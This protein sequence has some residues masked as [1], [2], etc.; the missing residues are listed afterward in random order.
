MVN[1]M[2]S[3]FN[4][5]PKCASALLALACAVPTASAYNRYIDN[6]GDVDWSS[7]SLVDINLARN[8]FP[9]PGN[10]NGAMFDTVNIVNRN[11][12]HF[13]FDMNNDNGG[14]AQDNGQNEIW[15]DTGVGA[16]GRAHLRWRGTDMVEV[17][18]R[19]DQ[20]RAWTSSNNRAS[21]GAYDGMTSKIQS[22]II[23][24]L[25]H[26]FP[27]AHETDTYNVMG[28]AW[29]F[30]HADGNFIRV[31]VGEDAIQGMRRLYG[32]DE[33]FSDLS[34]THWK[35]T[36]DDG[37]Y[38]EHGRT[39]IQ[40]AGGAE[41]TN[42]N[43]NDSPRY[44]VNRGDTV[45]VEFTYENL[46][47]QTENFKV[48]LYASTSDTITSDD[49]LLNEVN[50][51]LSPDTAYTRK[52]SVDIPDRLLP[53]TDYSIGVI[54]DNR[55]SVTEDPVLPGET[56]NTSYIHIRTNAGAN[57]DAFTRW[58]GDYRGVLDGEP[59]RLKIDQRSF[60]Q[61]IGDRYD[62]ELEFLDS[63][64]IYDNGVSYD[65][66]SEPQVL[67]PETL[68]AADRTSIEIPRLLIHGFDQDF[69]SGVEEDGELRGVG[70]VREG[71]KDGFLFTTDP[72]FRFSR[73]KKDWTGT[74]NG[75]NDGRNAR[76]II[77]PAGVGVKR[78]KV[79]Q[80]FDVTLKD[81]D[82]NTTFRGTGFVQA[83]GNQS[84]RHQMKFFSPLAEAGGSGDKIVSRL[85][86]HT[87][88]RNFISGNTIFNDSPFGMFF[89]R[90]LLIYKAKPYFVIGDVDFTQDDENNT[91]TLENL[92]GDDDEGVKFDPAEQVSQF[93]VDLEDVDVGDG[94]EASV[95][96]VG[97]GDG[98]EVS[99]RLGSATLSRQNGQ[100]M[101][102][103]DFSAIEASGLRFEV[104]IFGDFQGVI[105][106]TDIVHLLEGNEGAP[107]LNG[108]GGF[109]SSASRFGPGA[110]FTFASP[111]SVAAG[112]AD[113]QGGAAVQQAS[114]LMG[115]EIRV[116]ATGAKSPS[117]GLDEVN[118]LASNFD[119]LTITDETSQFLSLEN[120]NTFNPESL[121]VGQQ[122]ETGNWVVF[123]QSSPLLDKATPLL[124][125]GPDRQGA[126]RALEVIQHY[127]M[128]KQIRF[129]ESPLEFFLASGQP[130]R[131]PIVGE[132][133]V[134]FDPAALSVQQV[135]ESWQVT[136][137]GDPIHPELSFGTN[138]QAAENA[139]AEILRYGFTKLC[140]VGNPGPQMTYFTAPEALPAPDLVVT[141]LDLAGDSIARIGEQ[142][143]E[144]I[145]VTV[146]N[147]S[148]S[149]TAPPALL[150]I[151]LSP[152]EPAGA[153]S[154]SD[155]Q[156]IGERMTPSLGPDESVDLAFDN[157]AKIP[158]SQ[159]QQGAYLVAFADFGEA[160][161]EQRENNN[162]AIFPL[163]IMGA[164]GELGEWVDE[165]GI[166]AAD[167]SKDLDNDGTRTLFEYFAGNDPVTPDAPVIEPVVIEEDGERFLALDV[168]T[169]SAG[170][171]PGVSA[172][173][174][175]SSDLEAFT[176]M[177][178][179][180]PIL[181]DGPGEKNWLRFRQPH[182]M[183][184]PGFDPFV[185][186]VVSET[187]E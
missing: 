3:R 85:L 180:A 176:G 146:E 186:L 61:H 172:E 15:F 143:G 114:P 132:D 127:E 117:R 87:G 125:F 113:A 165:K 149:E 42:L 9:G 67:E 163:G 65:I 40:D 154:P 73:F 118:L 36:G 121:A 155:F 71:P 76:L 129:A 13:S 94:S 182:P 68:V 171:P 148:K 187:Q 168:L 79:F 45:Q 141:G 80:K 151:L 90:K 147:Q 37:E 137:L 134:G 167:L 101:L 130:P 185:Q 2:I 179:G 109:D 98:D 12:S 157:L 77:K 138:R 10:F 93:E 56:N 102:T 58:L 97:D 184:E 105:D 140:F 62:I 81:Q 59:V 55:D 144:R 160:I 145:H 34:V 164:L 54:V 104:Y 136:E 47:T 25:G 112:G 108:A 161:P 100:L 107:R 72:P 99:R 39:E 83:V 60:G 23:H 178:T 135:N 123:D 126:E 139:L 156:L 6:G 31:Y 86:I 32:T 111:V 103:G 11:P 95:E 84:E 88:D 53:D 170:V 50:M 27:L 153:V 150:G 66:A 70:F 142:L 169:G 173:L 16:A 63:G 119:A 52:F 18:V 152:D 38:S 14:V 92:T 43:T 116:V 64:K 1:L 7:P 33:H 158:D 78:F 124:A 120:P 175:S 49:L 174:R 159:P 131:G 48:G 28:D 128:T 133:C 57:P 82:R 5:L 96:L 115:N 181:M 74:Y 46:G 183:D 26:G 35:R 17:D 75:R 30:L 29:Q 24:E 19:I 89:K 8:S 20:T 122:E 106:D 110:T 166:V 91:V 4:I 22:V 41:L 21:I 69:I 162:F 44:L 51:T 177:E